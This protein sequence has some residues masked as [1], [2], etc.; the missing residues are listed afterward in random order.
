MSEK[1]IVSRYTKSLLELAVERNA[2]EDIHTDMLQVS[3]VAA[4]NRDLKLMLQNPVIPHQKK[5][6]ILNAIFSG[7]VNELTLKFFLLLTQKQ[8]EFYLIDIAK[9]FHHQYNV[10]H[11][12]EEATVTTTFPLTDALRNDFKEV[13]SGIS[14]KKVALK[15][16]IDESIIGGFIL[17]INDRQID[18][19]IHTRLK[20]L[21]TAFSKK[22]YEK[23]F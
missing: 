4:N 11:G 10:H 15:E 13:V 20:A 18:D 9:E 17:R 21:R 14:N 22:Q 19:S 8:R 16:I 5:G 7:K 12:I 1:R 3:K 2:L 6:T 23:A